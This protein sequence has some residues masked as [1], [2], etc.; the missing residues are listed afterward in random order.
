MCGFSKGQ[1][2]IAR[3]KECENSQRC[4]NVDKLVN[5]TITS[6]VQAKMVVES[7]QEA[8]F[9][10]E[11]SIT[12]VKNTLTG[13][14]PN[15]GGSHNV[16]K[17][18]L[19]SASTANAS[20]EK[21]V[22]QMQCT[23]SMMYG[24]VSDPG[25]ARLHVIRSQSTVSDVKTACGRRKRKSCRKALVKFDELV[26]LMTIEKPKDKGEVDVN[27]IMLDLVDRSDEVVP[28]TDGVV[29]SRIVYRVPKEQRDG[30]TIREEQQSSAETAE[31]EL[32]N[33]ASVASVR[34]I[35]KA[36]ELREDKARWSVSSQKQNLRS[37]DSPKIAR[38]V[39]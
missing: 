22:R 32:V 34:S 4:V 3:D 14:L 17:E 33:A 35:R 11:T 21:S 29:K 27:T 5:E 6:S 7:D 10:Q 19:M 20:I 39:V 23:F 16:S 25:S 28:T 1:W 26:M 36:M 18:S 38:D 31:G 12:D 37:V 15:V 30:A 13:E 8:K 24:T 2:W 9:Y